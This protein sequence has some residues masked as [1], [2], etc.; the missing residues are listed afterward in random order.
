MQTAVVPGCGTG[1]WGI[2]WHPCWAPLCLCSAPVHSFSS[3]LLDGAFH[4]CND[5]AVHPAV[6]ARSAHCGEAAQT[7]FPTFS[8][9]PWIVGWA[10]ERFVAMHMGHALPQTLPITYTLWVETLGSPS[11]WSDHE[12]NRGKIFLQ[13][14]CFDHE[15]VLSS[16]SFF[17]LF[18]GTGTSL[19]WNDGKACSLCW[20]TKYMVFHGKDIM[21]SAVLCQIE[22]FLRS[23]FLMSS[24][25]C[26]VKMQYFVPCLVSVCC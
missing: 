16:L 17:F 2:V 24:F 13:M 25:N 21:T 3:V 12:R 19:P 23:K 8:A 5:L 14:A 15:I 7:S 22:D 1:T 20:G 26:M 6:C 10:L 18:N 9:N 11:A 4:E